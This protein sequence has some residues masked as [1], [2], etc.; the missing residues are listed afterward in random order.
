MNDGLRAQLAARGISLT[1]V[2]YACGVSRPAVSQWFIDGEQ[3]RPIP[4][5]HSGDR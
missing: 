4:A 2:A 1:Q 5:R 3:W